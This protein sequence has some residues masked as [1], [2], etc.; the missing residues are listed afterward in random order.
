MSITLFI[1]VSEYKDN[2]R[3]ITFWERE[4]YKMKENRNWKLNILKRVQVFF[5]FIY[6]QCI[7]S[8][9]VLHIC[10]V[11]HLC[12]CKKDLML[13]LYTNIEI[14]KDCDI[15]QKVNTWTYIFNLLF[16]LSQNFYN[17]HRF[18]EEFLC[19]VIF[20]K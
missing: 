13:Y 4:I 10:V 20:K 9:I 3:K 1:I 15:W 7:L 17:T 18:T 19:Y 16:I 14:I 11:L 12:T 6:F 2:L 5:S 8:A